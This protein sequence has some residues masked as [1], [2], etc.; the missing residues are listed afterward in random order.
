[1]SDNLMYVVALARNLDEAP[2]V[3]HASPDV[4]SAAQRNREQ[5]LTE[6]VNTLLDS[7]TRKG[8]EEGRLLSTLERIVDRRR[9]QSGEG[10]YLK[11]KE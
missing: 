3:T 10:S 4:H 11:R 8:Y 7:L 5:A 1:M 6:L 9:L 2:D